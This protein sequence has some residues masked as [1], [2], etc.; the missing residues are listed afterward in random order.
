MLI[1]SFMPLFF[2]REVVA[3]LL[4]PQLWGGE[5]VDS[6]LELRLECIKRFGDL[7]LKLLQSVYVYDE[8]TSAELYVD[9]GA[10]IHIHGTLGSSQFCA[11]VA[12]GK[13]NY[14]LDRR[15]RDCELPVFIGK[16]FISILKI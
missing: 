8:R 10:I 13:A 11:M 1:L 6:S 12:H 9:G 5:V 16:C 4:L 2:N 7:H 3:K 14:I 15:L